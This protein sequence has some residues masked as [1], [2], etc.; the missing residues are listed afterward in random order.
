MLL[1][2]KQK[3]K[4]KNKCIRIKSRTKIT[5]GMGIKI[6]LRIKYKEQTKNT[7]RRTKIAHGKFVRKKIETSIEGGGGG[8]Q[9]KRENQV[10]ADCRGKG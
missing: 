3:Y 7:I 10:F 9:A 5:M 8:L 4:K 6:N 2:F 1:R